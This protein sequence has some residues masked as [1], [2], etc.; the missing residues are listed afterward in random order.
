MS[1]NGKIILSTPNYN[2]IYNY[3]NRNVNQLFQ[4]EPPIHLNFFTAESIKNVFERYGFKDCKVVVKKFPYLELSKKRFYLNWIKALF[5]K[6]Q[7]PTIYLE[8]TK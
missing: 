2:K 8:A 6:Y 5:N 7:G 4:N 1:V 3:P